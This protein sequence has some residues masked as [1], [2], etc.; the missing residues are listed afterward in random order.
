MT[1]IEHIGI[2]VADIETA[3]PLYERLLNANCYKT[4]VVESQLV[5]T[6]FLAVGPNKI[7]LVADTAP[8][9]TI[10]KYI[11]KRGEGIHHVAFEVDDILG[12]MARLR[13]EGFS[14]LSD[15]PLNGADNKWVCFVHPKNTLG[16]LVELCQTKPQPA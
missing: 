9:D 12:E 7:E 6:A 11:D 4:E 15:S 5:T 13:A 3:V 14:L 1:K 2:A 8:G 10:S 16:V